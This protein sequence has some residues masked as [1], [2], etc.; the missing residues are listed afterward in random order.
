[1]I[2]ILIKIQYNYKDK[3]LIPKGICHSTQCMLDELQK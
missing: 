3:D 1:M 2:Q